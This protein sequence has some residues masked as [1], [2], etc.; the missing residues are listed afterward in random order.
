MASKTLELPPLP[1]PIPFS[2][3]NPFGRTED[4]PYGFKQDGTPRKDP[5]RLL[6]A[7]ESLLL[8]F[9]LFVPVIFVLFIA[10]LFWSMPWDFRP[11][12]FPGGDWLDIWMP[13]VAFGW[14][15]FGIISNLLIRPV[16][17]YI[18]HTDSRRPSKVKARA[19]G[20]K[21]SKVP[22]GYTPPKNAESL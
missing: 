12:L 13:V 16:N 6:S 2:E 3:H 9:V 1:D 21:A 11:F 8:W 17:K 4:W 18:L 19:L 5:I 22:T 14:L 10:P 20:V 7:F 15:P